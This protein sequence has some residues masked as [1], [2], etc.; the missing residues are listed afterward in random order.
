VGREEEE[1]DGTRPEMDGT[2]TREVRE[3]FSPFF[4]VGFN[5]LLRNLEGVVRGSSSQ[6]LKGRTTLSGASSVLEFL[7]D[8]TAIFI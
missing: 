4:P 1:G 8:V 3:F 6:K 7:T 2:H 5:Y